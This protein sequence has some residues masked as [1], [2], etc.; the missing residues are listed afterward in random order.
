M[1]VNSRLLK[2]GCRI[3]TAALMVLAVTFVAYAAGDAAIME[4][5]VTEDS[6]LLYVNHVGE[7]LTA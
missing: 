6:I 3:V 1:S 7:N 4:Q 2:N 5:Y